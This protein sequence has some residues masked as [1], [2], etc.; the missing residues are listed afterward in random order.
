MEAENISPR[1]PDDHLVST[2]LTRPGAKRAATSPRTGARQSSCAARIATSTMARSPSSSPPHKMATRSTASAMAALCPSDASAV[3]LS[4]TFRA[5]P[6]PSAS[7][8][9]SP[10]T[11]AASRPYSCSGSSTNT[12]TPDANADS[13]SVDMRCVFP[14]PEWPNTPMFAL[15]YRRSSKGSTT[16]GVPVDRLTPTTNPAGCWRSASDQG[17]SVTSVE[18]SRTRERWSGSRPNGSVATRPASMSNMHG[19]RW[20]SEARADC[21]IRSDPRSSSAGVAAVKVM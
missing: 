11:A 7:R 5:C 18:L 12:C 9:S 17:K 4:R 3:R 6:D 14:A 13:A 8:M 1:A 20:T 15:A 21:S 2:A 16:T 10:P 19:W